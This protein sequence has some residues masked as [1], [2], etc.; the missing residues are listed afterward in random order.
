M[1]RRRKMTP[2]LLPE[3]N[4]LEVEGREHISPAGKECQVGDSM[5]SYG[6]SPREADDHVTIFA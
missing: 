4:W 3:N 1:M 6:K 2:E 5:P